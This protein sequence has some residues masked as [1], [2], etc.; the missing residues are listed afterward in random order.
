MRLTSLAALLILALAAHPTVAGEVDAA[1]PDYAPTDGMSASLVAMGADTFNNLMTFLAEEFQGLQPQVRID[2]VGKGGTTAWYGLM[3]GADLGM[4]ARL[5][6]EKEVA[7]FRDQFGYPPTAIAVAMDALAVIVHPDNPL[8]H[9]TLEQVD[10]IF[11]S[12]RK[13][14][15]AAVATWGDLGLGGGW[16]DTPILA[17]GRNSASGAYGFFKFVA[18][19]RGDFAPTVRE[20]PGSAAVVAAVKQNREAVGYVGAGFPLDGCRALPLVAVEGDPVA[21]GA[22]TVRAGTYPLGRH[23]YL[24]LNQKPG[25]RN[26]PVR[27]FLTYVLSKAGQRIVVKDGFI[28]LDAELAGVQLKLLE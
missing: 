4:A 20:L 12:T 16:V 7:S 25:T 27:A 11:S 21:P 28:P 17:R 14:G 18:L 3:H 15:G 1:L 10:A 19:Q 8:T 2:I 5:F 26:E 23:L 9:L 6:T 13:R 22:D 24:Y